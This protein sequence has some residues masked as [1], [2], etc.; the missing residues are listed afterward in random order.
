MKSTWHALEVKTG[1]ELAIAEALESV[2]GA[3]GYVPAYTKEV[4]KRKKR[5]TVTETRIG[6]P[7]YVLIEVCA[8]FCWSPVLEIDY[9]HEPIRKASALPG[10]YHVIPEESIDRMRELE[11]ENFGERVRRPGS[12]PV[13]VGSIIMELIAGKETECRVTRVSGE[14]ARA[15]PVGYPEYWSVDVPLRKLQHA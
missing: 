14:V 13:Q 12:D 8:P 9:V 10:D 5:A 11:A 1:K 2:Q 15:H 4:R 3:S 6:L 7:G